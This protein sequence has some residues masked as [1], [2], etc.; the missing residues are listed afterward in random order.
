M[1][2]NA[3]IICNK[4]DF[5]GILRITSIFISWEGHITENNTGEDVKQKLNRLQ[6]KKP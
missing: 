3:F 6:L 4:F 5:V 2:L 1:D